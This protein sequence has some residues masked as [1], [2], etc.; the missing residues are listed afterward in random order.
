MCARECKQPTSQFS[1]LGN[2]TLTNNVPKPYVPP[3]ICFKHGHVI[4]A[5]KMRVAS[6]GDAVTKED[7]EDI[8]KDFAHRP[9]RNHEEGKRN[10]KNQE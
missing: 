5:T 7:D 9:K 4:R 2:A 3:P 6:P 8:K 10:L 1:C